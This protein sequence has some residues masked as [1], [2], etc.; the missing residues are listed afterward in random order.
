[1]AAG[2]SKLYEHTPSI[3]IHKDHVYSGPWAEHTYKNANMTT[4][5]SMN[6]HVN[7]CVS[8]SIYIYMYA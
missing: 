7:K 2:S 1:M 8:L 3:N 6:R 5:R 4:D